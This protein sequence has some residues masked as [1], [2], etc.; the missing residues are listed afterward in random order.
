MIA[1]F[2]G[3][4]ML[5]YTSG[6]RLASCRIESDLR[7]LARSGARLQDGIPAPDNPVLATRN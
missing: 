3:H 1:A 2:A 4:D 6:A 7:A 5:G